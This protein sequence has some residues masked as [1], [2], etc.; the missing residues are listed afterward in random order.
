MKLK[1]TLLFF[2]V[3][4]FTTQAQTQASASN[5]LDKAYK[6]ATAENKNVFVK[7]S[8]SWCGWCKKMDKQM[9]NE[10]CKALFDNNYVIVTLVVHE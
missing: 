9:K 4:V 6:Q 8:A 2:I 1:I 7:Y 10:S 3:S 5:I